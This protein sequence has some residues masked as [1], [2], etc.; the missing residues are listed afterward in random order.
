MTRRLARHSARRL[1]LQALALLVAVAA[2]AV[3]PA[4]AVAQTAV[5]VQLVLAVDVSGSVSDERFRLQ[6]KGYA[7]AFRSH[8]LLEAIGSGNS[9]AI[10]VTMTQWT[11]P[12]Q[13]EVVVEWMVIRDE[14]SMLAFADA[15][16]RTTRR[17]YGGG[18]SISGAIEH[19]MTRFAASKVESGRRIIDVSGDGANNRGKPAAEARDAAVKAGITINGLPILALEP[20][21]DQYYANNV[22]GGPNAFHLVAESYDTFAEAVLKKLI[23][24][25]SSTPGDGSAVEV[26]PAQD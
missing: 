8:R 17:L 10:A 19:A 12:M 23:M 25:I 15:I 26:T 24:E 11:G 20:H 22:I 5:D 18:T 7:Q 14:A 13:Q 9:R 4:S 1:A 2:A 16:D 3:A 6:Q 21:L